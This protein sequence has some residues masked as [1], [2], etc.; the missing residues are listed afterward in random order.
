MLQEWAWWKQEQWIK[1]Y[2][3]TPEEIDIDKYVITTYYI[4]PSPEV[5][6]MEAGMYIAAP[7]YFK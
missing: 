5:S 2:V 1:T 7:V 3:A 4:K 6:L